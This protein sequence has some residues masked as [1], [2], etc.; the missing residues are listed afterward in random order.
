[1]TA[2]PPVTIVG[3]GIA[4]LTLAAT[5]GQ[6]GIQHRVVDQASGFGQVGAGIQLAPNA[7]RLLH[8]LGLAERLAADAVR[9][10]AMQLHRWHDDHLLTVTTLG[11]AC[12]DA[13]GAPYYT[14]H[15]ADLHS[16]L[17]EAA[18][19]QQVGMQTR[20]VGLTE[21]TSAVELALADGS[22]ERSEVVVGADGIHSVVRNVIV[23]DEPRFAGGSIFRGLVPADQ[24]PELARVPMIRMWAGPDQHCVCYPVSGGRMISFS[25]TVPTRQAASES[26]SALGSTTELAAAYR[27][28]NPVL[29]RLLAAAEVVGRWDLH[30]REPIPRWTT[31]RLAL[32]GDAA[33]PMLPFMAQGGNQAI[34]DAVALGSF[35]TALGTKAAPTALRLYEAV[36]APRVAVIQR[37]SRLGPAAMARPGGD[38][39]P[40]EVSAQVEEGLERLR[41]MGWLY[42]YDSGQA[43]QLA[44][45][46]LRA[47]LMAGSGR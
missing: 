29:T 12:E 7:V 35:L 30:D 20:V 47:K 14:V 44:T 17:A 10:Q 22:V 32:V 45:A 18:G 9:P 36:R 28:W 41:A 3:A 24:V 15:R 33:H 25:A 40:V 46:R 16:V 2:P 4:G 42:G 6:G 43:A 23:R 34:E 11:Q 13:Y 27:G 38:A 31:A 8:R 5:L 37:G 26:W 19:S 21:R 1:L 39:D